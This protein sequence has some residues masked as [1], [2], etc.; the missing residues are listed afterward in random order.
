LILISDVRIDRL[1]MRFTEPVRLGERMA[2][3]REVALVHV[4]ADDE[5]SGVGELALDTAG[6]RSNPAAFD[7]LRGALVGA[8][9]EDWQRLDETLSS[10]LGERRFDRAVRA[11]VD[12]A[13]LD[14]TGRASGTSVGELIGATR[15]AVRVN[16][17]LTASSDT[18]GRPAALQEAAR[19]L[20]QGGFSTLKI[21]REMDGPDPIQ[22]VQSVREAVGP[23]VRLRLDLNGDLAEKE[24]IRVLRALTDVDLEY[25]EQPTDP[26]LGAAALARVRRAVRVPIAADEAVDDPASAAELIATGAV[27]VLVVKPMR[28]GG[29]RAAIRIARA[30]ADAGVR[31]TI[32]TFYETGVG[33][34]AAL[35]VAAAIPGDNAHG[36]A[37]GALLE[38]DLIVDPLAVVDGV[39]TVPAGPG[40]GV[41]LDSAAVERLRIPTANGVVRE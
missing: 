2:S 34:A 24:A 9:A 21:K 6:G 32:S 22:I 3:W 25:V 4:D 27:D 14:L 13:A 12:T 28:V 38:D 11:A 5:T 10:V 41:E 33:L 23:D 8:D 39:M 15:R 29:P 35:H 31:T 36:L 37:T 1:S 26:S 40:L 7:I 20:V 17:V 30:A 18:Q 19:S 16:A